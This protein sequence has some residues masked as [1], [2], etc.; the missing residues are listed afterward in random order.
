MVQGVCGRCGVARNVYSRN[1]SVTA[2]EGSREYCFIAP[3]RLSFV[4]L[5]MVP[6]GGGALKLGLGLGSGRDTFSL[7]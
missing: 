5:T 6:A 1:S 2:K 4:L 3:G 7:G